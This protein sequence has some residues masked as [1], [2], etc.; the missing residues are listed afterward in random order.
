MLQ[1]PALWPGTHEAF[2]AEQRVYLSFFVKLIVPTADEGTPCTLPHG[3]FV[4]WW[5]YGF[6]ARLQGDLEE[7]GRGGGA[8]GPRLHAPP[9]NRLPVVV[10]SVREVFRQALPCIAVWS[11]HPLPHT[12][13]VR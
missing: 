1:P 2:S 11:R 7:R 9:G 3:R 12:D 13:G 6:L 4:R 8:C 5:V 10:H